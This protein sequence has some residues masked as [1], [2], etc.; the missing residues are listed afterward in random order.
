M[1]VAYDVNVITNLGVSADSAMVYL[2]QE[3]APA[4]SETKHSY[5]AMVENGTAHFPAVWK[6]TYTLQVQKSGFDTYEATGI[7]ISEAGSTNVEL[8]E[9]LLAPYNLKVELDETETCADF[10]WNQAAESFFDDME[11][12]E[13]F[14][15][16]EIGDYLTVDLD[17][18][19]TYFWDNVSAPN[20]N[21]VGSFMVVDPAKTDPA[22]SQSDAQPYS[23]NQYLACFDA[24]EDTNDDWL[25]LPGVKAVDGSEFSFYGKT[26]NAEY[27]YERFSVWVSTTGTN[28][29]D[30]FV[31]IS[32]GEY[33]VV[34]VWE[35]ADNV[36]KELVA[37][38]GMK[39]A[40][41]VD[42]W[43]K[44]EQAPVGHLTDV[45]GEPGEND[46]EMHDIRIGT[47]FH[48]ADNIS[49]PADA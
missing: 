48:H 39:V 8:K 3:D 16:D 11:S 46:T 2:T 21:Y 5:S 43:E 12:Y 14:T 33:S 29:P 42:H 23:G 30:G 20:K 22:Q 26:L 38:S 41:V 9:A 31:K 49:Q 36:R 25:I 19:A 15:V 18:T 7:A 27:G 17:G 6:G 47:S 35:T 44:N 13:A 1:E 40:A 28:A 32:E 10:T 37:R 45:L 4:D 24:M 34:G